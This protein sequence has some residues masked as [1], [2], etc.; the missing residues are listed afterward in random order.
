M[1]KV[2]E[3][4]KRKIN[5]LVLVVVLFGF[6]PQV[7]AQQQDFIKE[8]DLVKFLNELMD[9]KV[10]IDID[11]DISLYEMLPTV[12]ATDQVDV[13]QQLQETNPGILW[14]VPAVNLADY[15]LNKQAASTLGLY[16][17]ITEKTDVREISILSL[18]N[19]PLN[20][21]KIKFEDARLIEAVLDSEKSVQ[22]ENPLMGLI[23]QINENIDFAI[24]GQYV[25]D[26][27]YPDLV[28]YMKNEDKSKSA[29][30]A[31]F[32]LRF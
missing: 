7:F 27:T 8:D 18:S 19:V 17:P 5:V 31:K 4:I 28:D 14:P 16:D 32:T 25:L 26:M 1:F 15:A 24:V 23:W 21:Q 6:C 10:V 2:K 13:Q 11:K 9:I 12:N 30:Y 20:L 29:L 3:T 22:N